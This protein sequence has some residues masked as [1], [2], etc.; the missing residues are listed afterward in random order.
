MRYNLL[1]ERFLNPERV[2]MPDFDIDFCFNRREEVIDYCRK[3]YGAD[4][5]SQIITFGRMLAR[6]VVRNVG[7]VMGMPYGDVD[8]IAKLIPEE[9]KITLKDAVEKEPELKRIIGEDQQIAKLWRL[10][11][12]L[13]GTIGNCGTHAAGVVICDHAL[14]DH[15]ALFKAAN[16]DVVATQADM[17][18]VEELGLLKMDFLGLRT[19]TV[20]HEAVRIIRETRGVS[21]DIDNIATSDEKAYAL[22]RSG[23]TSG[24]FQLESS[25][26]RDLA[27]RIGLQS[28]EEM[29]ALVALFRPG[30]MQFIDTYI[31]NKFDSE[32]VKYD[33]P[34]LEPILKETYGIPVYQE[35]VMQ[36]AQALGGFSLGQADIMRRAM[37]KKKADLMAEQRGIFVEGCKKSNNIAE[38]LASELFD[39][40][41]TFAGY[42][43]NK[44]HSVAYAFVAYQTAFLKANYPAEFMCALLTS[45]SGNLDKIALYVEECRRMSVEVLPP[46]V[47]KSIGNFS[48][49]DGNI[50]FGL[51]AIKNVGEGP[52]KAIVAERTEGGPFKDIYD[53]CARLDNRMCNRRLLE[54]LNKAGA[55]LSTGW[56]RAQIDASLDAALEAGQS[57]A[58]DRAAGQFSLF[59]IA[60]VS[61]AM[62]SRQTQPDLPEWPEHDLLAYEKEMLGLYISSHPLARHADAIRR[63]SDLRL[64]E[65]KDLK[66]GA[67]VVVGGMIVTVKTIVTQ[68]GA[69]MA[70][71]T[72]D[73]L[74]G[75]C[76]ITVFSDLFESKGSMFVA[77]SIIMVPCRVNYRK[78]E[79]TLI[80][81]DVL[82][83]GDAEQRLVRAVHVR[84]DAIAAAEHG[85]NGTLDEV[86]G[87]LGAAQG[88]CDVY[89]HLGGHAQGDVVVHAN[90]ACRVAPSRN[91][92]EQLELLLGEGN[93]WFSGGMGLPSHQPP[94]TAPRDEPPW[95]RKRAA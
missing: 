19:L 52:T 18:Y 94:R 50:R 59:D 1:F 85:L 78:E 33:H 76:E 43:F 49:E 68:K 63:F 40:I 53:L 45:E 57:A 54:S 22:L 32:N 66:E 71:L 41:E 7:R 67:E 74:E 36:M 12:R 42:G 48:V 5:V 9:L 64:G 27:K 30:P 79:P 15:V 21:I 82:A 29:S 20:V 3:K 91:L 31:A 87:V 69:K 39:K 77:D 58:R 46:D 25:G 55:F 14:T 28:M 89:L 13:E 72:V 60:D 6:Q 34:L 92:K 62:E 35:Q 16:S 93:V 26:M 56:N 84:L 38:K 65:F 2:S 73:T 24:V 86:A 11:E 37:G 23:F 88:P 44:S 70:F 95:K 17:K 4:N 61:E 81:N 83:I 10:A 47:N 51:S 80:A 75:P 8:R 90:Q